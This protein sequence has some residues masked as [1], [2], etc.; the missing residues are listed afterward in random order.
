[1]IE[2]KI[3]QLDISKKTDELKRLIAEY[4]DY[5]IAVLAGEEAN[6]G[7]C[8]W[9][10]CSKVSFSV[11]EILDA[12]TP[13]SNND[14]VCCDRDEFKEA[15]Q[16]WLEDREDTQNLSN[17]EFYTLLNE[18]IAKYDSY[19]KKVITIWATN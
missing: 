19:W 5:E 12:E 15:M 13:Y 17:D 9:M 16:S 1:M 10:F 2:K 14:T 18:E 4:P 8:S 11:G 7:D 6:G 3:Y